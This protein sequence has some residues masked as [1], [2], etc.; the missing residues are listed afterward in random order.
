[1]A[2]SVISTVFDDAQKYTH[3]HPLEHK[4]TLWFDCPNKKIGQKDWTDH[5]K[6]I[7]TVDSVEDF[8]GVFNNIPK[9]SELT[10]GSNFHFFKDGIEPSWEDKANTNGGKW[11]FTIQ[12]SKPGEE[13]NKHWIDIV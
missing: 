8:W 1:M 6:N 4:W 10:V 2:T 3:K 5:L 9:A 11:T 12:K 13:L 7:V